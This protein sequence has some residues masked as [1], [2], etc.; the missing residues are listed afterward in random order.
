MRRDRVH[1]VVVIGAGAMGGW[2]A[3]NLLDSGVRVHVCD[4]WGAGNTRSSSGGESRIIRSG[5][6]ADEIYTAWA[7]QAVAKWK[8][9]E[10]RC[11]RQLFYRTGMLWLASG[12][13]KYERMTLAELRRQKIPAERLSARELSRRFPQIS[14][15]GISFGVYEPEGGALLASQAC[16]AVMNAVAA[17]GSR[18][19]SHRILPPVSAG[20]VR[21]RLTEVKSSSGETLSAAHFVFACG[22]WL[23]KMFPN[24]LR[25]RIRVTQQ[26][27]IYLS[28]PPGDGRFQPTAMPA[29]CDFS[30]PAYGIPPLGGH[31]FKVGLDSYGPAFDP[32]TG[33][34]MVRKQSVDAIRTYVARRFPS[35]RGQPVAE[36]HV[37]QYESTPNE[38]FV[39]DRHPRWENVWILGGGSGHA[40][41]MGPMIGEYAAARI[42][43]L[44]KEPP[45][46]RFLLGFG[47]SCRSY[48]TRQELVRR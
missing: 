1:D 19:T 2:T 24:L 21:S 30:I 20:T 41:K 5:Y 8:R 22:P 31:G 32:D 34:R 13:C 35:L 26:D 6:G 48:R 40:F 37:C 4:D 33:T 15:E 3:L 11:G 39:I 17:A 44:T 42:L 12:D 28:F 36:T 7:R 18:V 43:G 47:E 10:L 14:C 46:E 25:K 38:H 27:E 45:L 16:K 9:F 29:W 23:P